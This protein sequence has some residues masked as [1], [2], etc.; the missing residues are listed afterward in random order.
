M[1]K[2]QWMQRKGRGAMIWGVTILLL[3]VLS[4][5]VTEN[6]GAAVTPSTP[7][8]VKTRWTPTGMTW[9]LSVTFLSGSRQ[10]QSEVSLMTFL[11]NG[12]LTATFPQTSQ[13]PAI[14]GHWQMTAPMLSTTASASL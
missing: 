1:K 6:A 3:T 8:G 5:L 12:Q 7:H 9:T 2:N 4:L 10:G 11:P 13:L 14:D